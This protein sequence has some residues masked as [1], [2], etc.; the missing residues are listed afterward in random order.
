MHLKHKNHCVITAEFE[1]FLV[2][3]PSVSKVDSI[4]LSSSSL[5]HN[6]LNSVLILLQTD[7]K[8][9]FAENPA[10]NFGFS[11][12]KFSTVKCKGVY[13]SSVIAL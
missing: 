8:I 13:L 4:L 1:W 3:W 9:F 11:L 12:S 10:K 6:P 5:N 7:P 2:Y